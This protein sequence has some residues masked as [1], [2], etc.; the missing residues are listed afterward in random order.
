MCIRDRISGV[1]LASPY[2]MNSGR[3]DEIILFLLRCDLLNAPLP[4]GRTR[5]RGV[6]STYRRVLSFQVL[7]G[8]AGPH[9]P[10]WPRNLLRLYPVITCEYTND[11]VISGRESVVAH[12]SRP[13]AFV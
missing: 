13:E 12:C 7:T 10:V 11:Y 9:C 8:S 5:G 6:F 2:A 1:T 4:T 3:P